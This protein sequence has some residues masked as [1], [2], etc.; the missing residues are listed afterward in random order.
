MTVRERLGALSERIGL[1]DVRELARRVA[2]LENAMPEHQQLQSGLAVE[3]EALSG[4]VHAVVAR[5]DA[6][7][8]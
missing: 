3:I 8:R 4:R 7:S 1:A 2:E 5:R 6:A